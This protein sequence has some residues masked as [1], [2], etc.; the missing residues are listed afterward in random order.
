MSVKHDFDLAI[1]GGGSAGLLAARVAPKLGLRAVLIERSRLGG[2]CLWT[3]C[4][5]SKALL[6]SAKAAHTIRSAAKYGLTASE[7]D[8]DTTAVWRR[9]RE[10]QESIATGDDSSES[11]SA[12]GTDV[13]FGEATLADAHTVRVGERTL[14]AR[15]ILICT[16]SRPTAPPIDGLQDVGFLSSES[17]FQQERAPESLLIVG[18]GP[19]GVEMAQA[20]N[21]LG[22]RVTLLEM[23]E[24]LLVRDEPSLVALLTQS[25]REEGVEVITN[26]RLERATV[27]NGSKTL[28]GR[29]G[30]EERSWSAAEILVAAGRAPNIESLGLDNADVQVG[31]RGIVVDKSLRS[32]VKSVYAVG[33]CAGRF[34]FTHSAG[35]ETAAALRNMFYPGTTVAP[36]VVPWT[37]FTDPELAHIG[38]T[39]DEARAAHGDDNIRVYEQDLGLSDRGRAESAP[40]GRAVVVADQS[41]NILGAHILS[42]AAGEMIGQFTLAMAQGIKL[43]PAFRDLIQVYPT[44]S[45]GL[46]HLTE[47]AVYE[48]LDRPLYRA[49]RWLNDIV[50]R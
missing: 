43:M 25:L 28:H 2:D 37:T 15:Y 17:L 18:G 49:A 32:S 47:D 20:M 12:G 14:T 16:G 3:G 7:P 42:P 34:L 27:E 44:Y 41:H 10:I 19:I 5:P 38:M 29:L 24:R 13:V 31:P 48:N 46:S 23:A 33:D 6:A 26:A 50:S 36:E 40:P 8:I 1:I 4:V 21:R 30:E 39:A 11:V 45:T 9:I 35:A 22:V